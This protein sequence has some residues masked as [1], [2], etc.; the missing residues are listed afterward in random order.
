[1]TVPLISIVNPQLNQV[2][3]VPMY[4]WTLDIMAREEVKMLE[5]A[6]SLSASNAML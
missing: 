5:V 2:G 3:H 1:M 4:I 6:E